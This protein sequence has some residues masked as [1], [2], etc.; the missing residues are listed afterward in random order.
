MPDT[1]V[2]V[3]VAYDRLN[4]F[5]AGIVA[6][7]F[8]LPRPE[9]PGP[10]Y[11]LRV[12]QA[13]PGELRGPGGLR[14]C[15]D[16][17]LGLLRRA[18]LIV[19]PGWRNHRELP[20]RGL[21]QA[22]RAAHA[23]GAR[24]LSIC[25]GAFVLAATGLLDGRRA[26]T[27]WRYADAFRRMYPRVALD[28][29][30]LYVDEG[31][32]VTSAGSAAGIDACLHVVR[33]DHGAEVANTIARTMVSSPHRSGGQ[34]QYIAGPVPPR[35]TDGLAA[36]MDWARARIDRSLS[37]PQLARRAAMSERTFLR[38]F[39]AETGITPKRWLLHERVR[40]AQRMLEA[41]G[42]TLKAVSADAGFASVE[43]F[44]AVFRHITGV[45]PSEYRRS[46][47]SRAPDIGRD[48]KRSSRAVGRALRGAND[49]IQDHATRSRTT[50]RVARSGAGP[51]VP[52]DVERTEGVAREPR[53]LST[54]RRVRRS[55]RR[56]RAAVD[57]PRTVGRRRRAPPARG[58]R[59]R[60]RVLD[61]G[62]RRRR[63]DLGGD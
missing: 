44:R 49:R 11:A 28:D 19:I 52:P 2:V 46:F 31:D 16:G 54:G 23:R 9:L 36:V 56:Q 1:R 6:E 20:P 47:A 38:R 58:G 59:S 33:C 22:L 40:A 21:I 17:G 12:A 60:P 29:Q 34:A 24:L 27:H 50:R 37:V 4:L 32:V 5:E 62:R 8:G 63:R 61:R 35:E 51:R 48:H 3:A 39:V 18:D 41:P 10:L 42:A 26:T 43:T 25:T 57:P 13:E 14:L 7:V 45:A 55:R 30:V 15:A 53:T